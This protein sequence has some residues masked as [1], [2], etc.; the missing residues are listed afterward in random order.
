MSR[1][2]LPMLTTPGLHHRPAGQRARGATWGNN[3]MRLGSELNDEMLK[4][5]ARFTSERWQ[6]FKRDM[7]YFSDTMGEADY[8]ASLQDHGGDATLAWLVPAHLLLGHLHASEATL[9]AT[10]LIDPLLILLLFFVIARTF[11]L[12]A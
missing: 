2:W 11:G 3:Q 10:A 7:K 8:L 5:R 9:T 1:L 4:V 12:R 6:E